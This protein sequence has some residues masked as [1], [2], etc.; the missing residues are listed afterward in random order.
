MSIKSKISFVCFFLFVNI[1]WCKV[2]AP[3]F[4]ADGMVLQRDVKLPIWGWASPGEKVTVHFQKQVKTT[5]ASKDGSWRIY[6]DPIQA[7]GS[8]TMTLEGKNKLIFKDILVGDVFLAS[9]QSN[10]EFT[11]YSVNNSK[12]EMLKA[13]FSQIHYFRAGLNVAN[14]PIDTLS[15]QW[16]AVSPETVGNLSGVAYFFARELYLKKKIPI[17]I[18]VCAWGGS[19][20][21]SWTNAE[22]LQSFPEFKKPLEDLKTAQDW[23][24]TFTDYEKNL[25]AF[26]ESKQGLEKDVHQNNYAD[27]DWKET[28]FPFELKTM[29]L[30]DNYG[31]NIW[32][33]KKI[34]IDPS[35]N[36]EKKVSLF[37]GKTNGEIT[38]YVNGIEIQNREET[39]D[40]NW[41]IIPQNVLQK[42]E[43]QIAIKFLEIWNGNIG[44]LGQNVILKNEDSHLNINGKWKFNSKIEF[45]IPPYVSCNY[46]PSTIYNA[47]IAPLIPYALKGVIWYQGESNADRATQY[48]TLFPAL[49]EGWRKQWNADFPFLFVQ[50]ANFKEDK[51]QPADYQWAALRE[52]QQMTLKVPKTGMAVT[53]DIGDVNDIHPKNK[54]DVGKRLA[55]VAEKVIY[56]NNEIVYSGPTFKE[57]KTVNDS[58]VVEFTNVGTG[59]KVKDQYGYVKGF[60]IAGNDKVFKWA[61]GYQNGNTLILYNETIKNPTAVRYDWGNSPDGNIYNK[62]GLP[63]VPFRTDNYPLNF[64]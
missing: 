2:S 20:A 17:G 8:Y 36:V 42:G 9:G 10:M 34:T 24:K 55:L 53:I 19:V 40:G 14:K 64:E 22:A 46:T 11:T 3:N 48:Q 15:G 18:I 51:K 6:L 57:F 45:P 38:V 44:E 37:L 43:N 30:A 41:F 54:Q 63:A 29:G 62:E 47:M 27:G 16:K 58:I 50:L 52:A 56:D 32:L 33:R 35:F 12:D 59:L 26:K 5:T 1:V 31:N 49:I 13:D 7:G 23:H 4:V 25:K 61:K 21:E 28:E 60:A 39:P